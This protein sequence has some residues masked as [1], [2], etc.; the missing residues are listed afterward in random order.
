MKAEAVQRC[1]WIDI[2]YATFGIIS[3]NGI[4][5]DAAPIAAW[6]KGKPLQALKPFLKGKGAKVEEI[7]PGRAVL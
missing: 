2:G 7:A 5:V 4:V 1:F 6:M 3:E